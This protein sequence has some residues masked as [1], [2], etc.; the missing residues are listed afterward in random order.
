[1]SAG[2]AQAQHTMQYRLEDPPE[3]GGAH[4]LCSEPRAHRE[5]DKVG[6]TAPEVDL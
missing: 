1:M 4:R 2:R 5:E 6:I 3:K